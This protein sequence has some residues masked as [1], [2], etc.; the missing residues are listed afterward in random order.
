LGVT[1]SRLIEG[2]YFLSQVPVISIIDDDLSVRMA[3]QRLVRSLGYSAQTFSSA[4]EFLRSSS[5]HGTSCLI[6]DVQLPGMSGVEL[7]DHLACEGRTLPIIFI[8]AF[9]DDKIRS[10]AMQAGAIC[11]LTKPFDGGTL[12]Q[13]IET[14]LTR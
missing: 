13:C 3:I 11:F 7:Q 10:R 8:T 6:T 2:L 9:P 4:S 14:A 1:T 5:A 12:V